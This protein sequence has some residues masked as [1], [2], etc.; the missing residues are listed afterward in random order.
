MITTNDYIC[1]LLYDYTTVP[2]FSKDH[3]ML[4]HSWFH[5]QN[6]QNLQM[7]FVFRLF[8]STKLQLA[9]ARPVSGGP[10]G[11]RL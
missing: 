4:F 10:S 6:M 11:T 1:Q 3:K 5:C 9:L 2:Q 8:G 7:C